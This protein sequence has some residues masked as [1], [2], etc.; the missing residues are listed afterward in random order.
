MKYRIRKK[1]ALDRAKKAKWSIILGTVSTLIVAGIVVV[2][3][4]AY[5]YHWTWEQVSYWLN[6][7]SEGNNWAWIAY[8]L[9]VGLILL[10]IYL[11]HNA[12]LEKIFNDDN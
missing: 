5:T 2:V 6:P 9:L 8:A 1:S 7:F 12:R 3:T 4:C 11:I 10:V